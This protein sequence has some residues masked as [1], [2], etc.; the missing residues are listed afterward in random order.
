MDE[1]ENDHERRT[2]FRRGNDVEDITEVRLLRQKIQ[3]V[4]EKLDREEASD[5]RRLLALE[6]EIA[7]FKR[8]FAMGKGF[9]YG[10]LFIL[11]SV[12]VYLVDHMK[13]IIQGIA[14]S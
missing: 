12:G 9:F 2:S 6:A 4:Q 5:H 13:E 8:K 1:H 11:G 10:S 14:K 7:E 3:T